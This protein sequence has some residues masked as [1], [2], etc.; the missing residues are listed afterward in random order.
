MSID[1]E[2]KHPEI[3]VWLEVIKE[4]KK[5]ENDLLD[6]FQ[7]KIF[8]GSK[9]PKQFI[10]NILEE[11]RVNG[12]I[13][14]N[15]DLTEK[16]NNTLENGIVYMPQIGIY[17]VS[18]I[19]DS[20]FPQAIIEFSELNP[21]LHDEI[22]R[23]YDKKEN[24]NVESI[25]KLPEFIY[26]SLLMGPITTIT[27]N[28]TKSIIISKI[29]E[30]GNK[31]V[32]SEDASFKLIFDEEFNVNLSV[33]YRN[34]S[35]KIDL[36]KFDEFIVV[37]EILKKISDDADINLYRIPVN[38][39]ETTIKERKNFLKDFNLSKIQLANLGEFETIKIMQL[40]IYP[41]NFD[42]ALTWAKELLIEEIGTYISK[43]ELKGNWS[44]I[45]KKIAFNDYQFQEIT[46][47]ILLDEIPFGNEKFWFLIAPEDL[48]LEKVMIK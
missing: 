10:K 44:K 9:K 31:L 20:I 48:E 33:D 38:H 6:Y 39:N 47:E 30:R 19:Q 5:S 7:N 21:S 43:K 8:A 1:I 11:L 45:T 18:V 15:Y 35:H 26:Q 13:E 37:E 23:R 36:P 4:A 34:N 14:N 3:V 16:G 17:E 29:D 22:M 25:I 42:S 32:S 24:N 41:K 12:F 2:E 28:K 27:N 40:L 46:K